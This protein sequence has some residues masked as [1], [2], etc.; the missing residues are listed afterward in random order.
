MFGIRKNIKTNET[1]I[2]KLDFSIITLLILYIAGSANFIESD[3]FTVTVF[4]ILFIIFIFKVKK[5][6]FYIFVLLLIWCIINGLSILVNGLGG[7]TL[8]SFLGVTIRMIMSYFILKI[9]GSDFFE[10]FYR[11][12]YILS[13]ISII[14]FLLDVLFHEVFV[15]LSNYLNFITTAEQKI[16]GGWYIYIYMFSAW[17]DFSE[18]GNCG[19]MWEPGGFAFV[20]VFLLLYRLMRNN[21]KLDRQVVILVCGLI[22]TFS[23]AG[24]ISLFIIILFYLLHAG[25]KNKKILWLIPFVLIIF[26]F[27]S[28]KFY[29]SNPFM[30]DK[31]EEYVDRGTSS[32]EWTFQDKSV[33]RVSRLGIAIIE[34]ESSLHW[35]FGNGIQKNIFTIEKYG[36]VFG[37]NSLADILRQWGWLGMIFLIYTFYLFSNMFSK[38]ILLSI[39]FILAMGGVMFSNPFVIKYLVYIIVFYPMTYKIKYKNQNQY[40][41]NL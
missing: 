37:P 35:P 3:Y 6:D 7:I 22:T 10:K 9:V 21:F 23:T 17:N 41:L 27:S 30:K 33:I 12:V 26:V 8:I 28:I 29:N 18:Y 34:L 16:Q 11:Y 32:Y 15:G 38:S 19:F 39:C 14:V 36:D 13:F 2:T 25:I 31:I 40:D 20:L 24:Y 5:I 1:K 4:V